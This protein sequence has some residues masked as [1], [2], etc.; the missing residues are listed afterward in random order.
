M[1]PDPRYPCPKISAGQ[2]MTFKRAISRFFDSCCVDDG[3]AVAGA[4]RSGLRQK[5]LATMLT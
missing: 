4:R 3:L 2:K 1:P 5:K